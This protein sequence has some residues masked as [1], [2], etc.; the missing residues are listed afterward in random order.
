MKAIVV[1]T[2]LSMIMA[3]TA[4]G[5]ETGQA[6]AGTPDSVIVGQ[7]YEYYD[8]YGNTADQI[9]NQMNANGTRWDDGQTYDSVTSWNL[10]WTYDYSCS[11]HS[12]RAGSFKTM[13]DITFR[14]PK[15]IQSSDTSP[16]LAQQWNTYMKNLVV[17]ENGHRDM[18]VEAAHQLSRDALNLPP[19]A[20]PEDLDREIQQMTATEMAKL[21]AD[22][23]EYDVTTVHGTTQG[24]VFP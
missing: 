16:D 20:S 3:V 2:A 7:K 23:K 6:T 9:R 15:W 13:V 18:A 17:H 19:A 4:C 14:F 24:A 12:C 8:V 22:E 21:N 11:N 10:K 1:G 5:A